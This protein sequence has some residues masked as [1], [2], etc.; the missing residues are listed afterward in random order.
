MTCL[1]GVEKKK[2]NFQGWPMIRL[3]AVQG[4]SAVGPRGQPVQAEAGE[5]VNHC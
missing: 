1:G 4:Q 3:E 2:K 5:G